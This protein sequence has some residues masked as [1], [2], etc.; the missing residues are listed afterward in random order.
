M[1]GRLLMPL[2]T[3]P[4]HVFIGD[5]QIGPDTPV[6]HIRWIGKYL[7]ELLPKRDGRVVVVVIGDWHDMPSLSSYDKPGSKNAE[8]QRI[9]ADLDAGNEQIDVLSD[10]LDKADAARKKANLP[11]IERH[12]FEGNHENRLW[13]LVAQDV[14][15]DGV[16]RQP[17]KWRKRGWKHHSFLDVV[18][19]DGVAYSHYFYNPMTG[20]P[21]SGSNIELR[22]KTIGCSFSMGHQQVHLTGMRQT[23]SGVQRGLV[24]GACY[25]H[26]EDYI[27]PQGN[28]E[29]RGIVI[30]NEVR[31]GAYDIME[32]SLD[33]LCR[34]YEQAPLSKFRT[35][36]T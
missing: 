14:K 31:D 1:T 30:K 3:P 7:L 28:G 15:F 18:K 11:R 27:G 5:T 13:R 23:I 9:Q 32:I 2:K 25:L 12:F 35:G 22:L 16:W 4:T 20:R 17:F 21:Y 8:N 33:Y 19:I 36:L 10:Y 29:W 6:D 24:S 34:R 26:D